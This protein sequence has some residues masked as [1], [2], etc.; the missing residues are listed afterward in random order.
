MNIDELLSHL[1]GVRE[2][3]PDRWQAQCPAHTDREPSLS[4]RKDT[5]RVLLHCHAGCQPEAIL[6]ALHLTMAD[7]FLEKHQNAPQ[8]TIEQVYPYHDVEGHIVFE[9]VRFKQKGFN[10]RQPDGNGGHVWNLK[11]VTPV[12]YCLPE[13][14]KAISSEEIIYIVEG[15]KDADNL[16]ALDLTATTNPM[17]A[18]KWREEYTNTLRGASAIILPDKDAPGINHAHQIAQSLHG[19]AASIKVVEL[20]G[21]GKDVSDW[22]NTGGN[23]VELECMASDAP[24]WTPEPFNTQPEPSSGWTCSE[25]LKAEFPPPV[26]VV[27]DLLPVGLAILAGRPKLG[28]SRLALQLAVSVGSGGVWLDHTIEQGPVLAFL[29]E[30]SPRRIQDRL[31]KIHAP[32]DAAIHFEFSLPSPLNAPDGLSA[33]WTMVDI[34]NPKLV[35]LDTLARC[36]NGRVDWNDVAAVTSGLSALQSGAMERNISILFVD[37]H[38][39]GSGESRDVVTDIVSSVSKPGV[40]DTIMGFYRSPGKREWTLAITGRDVEEQELALSYDGMLGCWQCMGDADAVRKDSV[41]A[42]VVAALTDLG[43]KATTAQIAE[44]T[45]LDRGLVSRTLAELVA[46]GYVSRGKR[47]G[48]NVPYSLL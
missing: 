31:R 5:D 25:L 17:G 8:R 10:Q 19:K 48:K 4:L 41:Q 44:Q 27:P 21:N 39:K 32:N 37:H 34:A 7:L 9:T 12:L 38:R 18:G 30:D 42:E 35:I 29:L 45:G 28:K 16:R 24:E 46:A 22:L 36:F 47:E 33:F 43:G 15:E 14:L 11:G 23:V 3:G 6:E 2:T 1:Q 20:P 26:W 40:A 13:V